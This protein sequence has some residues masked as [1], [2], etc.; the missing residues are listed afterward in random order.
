M[1]DLQF[2]LIVTDCGLLVTGVASIRHSPGRMAL[3]LKRFALHA[4][5]YAILKIVFN[6]KR[7]FALG[8]N[9]KTDLGILP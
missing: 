9:P 5:R 2:H 8:V 4:E 3:A 6:R 1:I 7:Y